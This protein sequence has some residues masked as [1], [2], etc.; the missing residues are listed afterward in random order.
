MQNHLITQLDLQDFIQKFTLLFARQKDFTLE[1]DKNQFFHYIKELD[2]IDFT[3]PPRIENL[4][5][6][7]Q[8]IKKFGILKLQE[9]FEFIKIIR[10]FIYL[11]KHAEIQ[12]TQYLNNYLQKI[13]LPDSLLEISKYFEKD[14]KIKSGIFEELDSLELSLKRQKTNMQQALELLLHSSKLAPYLVDSQI[15]FID[16]TQTLLVKPGYQSVITGVVL[17]RSHNGFFY[18][19]PEEIKSIYQ[20]IQEIENLIEETLFTICK[21]ISLVFNKHVLFLQFINKEFDK[22]DHIQ[23]RIFFAKEFN[24][25][26]ILPQYKNTHIVLKDFSHPILANPKPISIDFNKQLLLITGVNAGGKTMLLKSL[27]SAVFLSKHLIPFKIN[28]HHSQIPHF[29]NIFA[30][31]SDPQNSKNDISTFAGRMLDFSHILQEKEMLLGVDEIEL[32]TDADEAASLYKVILENLLTKNA[33]IIITTH[34]KR[35]AALMAN[36]S[37]I[38]LCAAIYDEEKQKP[39]FNF[40]Y[41]SIGKSYAFETAK[42]YKIPLNIIEEARKNYGQDKEKLNV[43]IE[44]S[45]QLEIN[46][47]QKIKEYEEKVALYNKKQEALQDLKQQYIH[48]FTKEKNILQNTYNQALKALKL[49]L[50]DK[51]T[52]D[53]HRNINHANKILNSLKIQT[54]QETKPKELSMGQRVKY[55]TS[56]ATILSISQKQV[57]IELD[58]GMRLKVPPHQLKPIGKE[59]ATPKKRIHIPIPKTSHVHLDLHGLRAEEALEK[60]DKF[61]SDSLLSGFDEVLVYHGIGTGIL[62]RVVREFLNTHPKVVSFED[63]PPQ[64]GGFGAKI[65]KL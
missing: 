32:G 15:H 7:L 61:L 26:F 3:P 31:I 16:Q 59:A 65:I 33:K 60:L 57:L 28:P 51:Q 54:T 48:D 38:Q 2:S 27:L 24:L 10:Y 35:L 37:R 8:I 20:K 44:K 56:K 62:S 40:L 22:I 58:E 29:K 11:K 9:I 55:K 13:Q 21:Q 23:A 4:D 53:I 6:S 34:H 52:S 14:G 25:N 64:M 41:G 47:Q 63:A 49:E 17:Q 12:K 5:S 46:L 45:A 42:R 18:L 36:D 19:L 30:I 1:G 43:L 50:K 39:T